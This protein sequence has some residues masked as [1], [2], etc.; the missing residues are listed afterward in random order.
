MALR[1]ARGGLVQVR[2]APS[3]RS[4]PWASRLE[5]AAGVLRQ[6]V[7]AMGLAGSAA[8]VLHDSPDAYAGV[9]SVPA[10]A[11]RR[12]AMSAARLALAE[13]VEFPVVQHPFGL[14][15]LQDERD[16]VGRG[17]SRAGSG[18]EPQC[19]ILAVADHDAR[20][21]A[22]AQMV[23]RCGLRPAE[24]MPAMAPMLVQAVSV[25]RD[26]SGGG[27]AAVAL[28]IS[29]H[30]S[31]LVIADAGRIRVVRQVD[32]GVE[33]LAVPV[34]RLLA[35]HDGLDE[36]GTVDL[37]RAM[38][39]LQSCG[40]PQ[41]EEQFDADRDVRGEAVLPLLRPTVQRWMVEL[42]QS[43]RYALAAQRREGAQLAVWGAAVPRLAELLAAECELMLT[44]V[45]A[46]QGSGEEAGV[47]VAL[48]AAVQH[49]PRRINTLPRALAWRRRER[50]V[51]QSL[52]VGCAA[53]LVMVGVE[54]ATTAAQLRGERQRLEVMARAV[55][56]GSS[57]AV[58][59]SRLMEARAA[60]E[61]MRA[62]M[63]EA[64]GATTPVGPL[65]EELARLTPVAFR[66]A[67]IRLINN[68]ESPQCVLHGYVRGA[69][70]VTTSE[71]LSR[72]V[73]ALGAM[74]L[75]REAELGV[76]GL[77]YDGGQPSREFALTL[78]LLALPRWALDGLRLSWAGGGEP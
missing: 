23:E 55:E 13:R 3:D 70:A 77:A 17:S 26:M 59:E 39:R 65:L 14:E 42:K 73:E 12:A 35:G 18:D 36:P 78:H 72:Y 52:G 20:A 56:A 7:D 34:A 31:A 22:V 43:V 53:A 41:P 57:A 47:P 5:L 68:G 64:M 2:T 16:V 4:R 69:D 66:L 11:G 45:P 46:R 38:S 28:L 74:P 9:I 60:L 49:R 61:S 75:A 27:Q 25:A 67:E 15:L 54:S 51:R 19:H 32:I 21:T 44:P 30:A 48:R 33:S 62:R 37:E 29:E 8:V 76:T 10:S 6:W 1:A 50:R 24:L 40:L 63:A 71:A 58:V